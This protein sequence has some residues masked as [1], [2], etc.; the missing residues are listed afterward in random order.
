MGIHRIRK[1][2]FKKYFKG[3]QERVQIGDDVEG[4]V[5][6]D[7]QISGWKTGSF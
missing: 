3:V 6:D 5:T 2:S 4:G 7:S 1:E